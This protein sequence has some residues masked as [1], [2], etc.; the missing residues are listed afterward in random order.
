MLGTLYGV[1]SQLVSEIRLADD[2]AAA[3]ADALL[4]RGREGGEHT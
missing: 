4:A 2:L 1:R 3:R